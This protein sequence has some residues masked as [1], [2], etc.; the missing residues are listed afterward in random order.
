[1]VRSALTELRIDKWLWA[2]RFHKTRSSATSA[3]QAGKVKLNGRSIKPSHQV[4]VGDELLITRPAY[5]QQVRVTGLAER[6]ASAVIAAGLYEDITPPEEIER[7]RV[8]RAADSAFHQA[9]PRTG[10]PTKRDRRTLQKLRG[11]F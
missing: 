9:R 5:R 11:K 4:K 8:Q 1:M 2:A 6:R 10:R 7:L 3:C